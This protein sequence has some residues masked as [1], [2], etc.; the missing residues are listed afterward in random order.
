MHN[1]YWQGF[2]RLAD[3]KISLASFASMFLA[4]CMASHA[5]PLVWGW[6]W[7]TVLG[8]FA[9]EVAKNASGQVV[10]Y[11]SGTDLAISPDD[12]S[13]FSGG[14]RVVVDGL[15]TEAQAL[16]IARLF[17]GI[18]VVCGLVIANWR[19]WRVLP[20]AL[21]GLMLAWY[22]HAAPLKLSYRGY[23][24]LAVALCY[25][26][27]IAGGTYLVQT[28]EITGDLFLTSLALGL[29]IAGFL[30]VNQFPDYVADKHCGK[31]NLVVQLGRR[32][33]SYGFAVLL[34]GS[35]GLLLSVPV[36]F[37]GAEG[38]LWGLLAL[39]PACFASDRV[40]RSP[41]DTAALIPAQVAT[42]AAFVLLAVGAGLGYLLT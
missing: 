20:I 11:R 25:G 24:E 23:G 31:R 32:K 8:I 3:P 40:L 21:L 27:L 10:D 26:P 4:A 15:L 12:R 34:A 39:G 16:Q 18:A 5:Q 17:Y 19:D 35:V 30:W 37:T 6:L 41:T 14:K 2:W 42:L 29:M 1:S 28:G 36:M 33:A 9:V 7:L 22:Y 38:V 13:P